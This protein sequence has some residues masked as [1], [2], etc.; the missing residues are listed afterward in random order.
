MKTIPLKIFFVSFG[1]NNSTNLNSPNVLNLY[2][3]WS[4]TS[5]KMLFRIWIMQIFHLNL[6]DYKSFESASLWFQLHKEMK[7]SSL[8]KSVGWF[9]ITGMQAK[10]FLIFSGFLLVLLIYYSISFFHA[11]S[12]KGI[13]K[14][15]E[16]TKSITFSNQDYNG[17]KN[18]FAFL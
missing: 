8:Q 1:F 13:I 10:E 6:S 7:I 18:I 14:K 4:I 12:L 16:K 2:T 3:T 15:K 9:N 17:S 11:L 5:S